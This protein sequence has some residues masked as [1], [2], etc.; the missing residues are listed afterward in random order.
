MTVLHAAARRGDLTEI[1]QW[2]AS[3]DDPNTRQYGDGATP[4]ICAAGS[5]AAGVQIVQ[6]LVKA[7]ADAFLTDTT[8]GQTA[9][10]AAAAIGAVD[11]VAYLLG[12]G[13]DADHRD[14]HGY[15]PIIL[16]GYARSPQK[17]EVI[18]LLLDHGANA[19]RPTIYK[20]TVVGACAHDFDMLRLFDR[21]K[22]INILR[23][24]PLMAATAWDT[25]SVM[26]ST[27]RT[28]P[29]FNQQDT[30]QRTVWHIAIETGDIAKVRWLYA[31][32]AMSMGEDSGLYPN[33]FYALHHD[34]HHM[35]RWLIDI[36]ADASARSTLYTPFDYAAMQGATTCLPLLIDHVQPQHPVLADALPSATDTQTI[37]ILLKAGAQVNHVCS[38]GT[39]ALNAA[40]IDGDTERVRVLLAHGA[41]PNYPRIP[42]TPLI[43][44]VGADHI[45]V[46]QVLLEAG[47]DPNL[48]TNPDMWFAL[49][50]VRSVRVMRL[51]LDAGADPTL[52]DAGGVTAYQELRDPRLIALLDG[53]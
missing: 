25:F 51:L 2:L 15:A 43:C 42:E 17:R 31:Q 47:A 22:V 19:Y 28:D 36:G 6:A 5:Q 52:S 32:P 48:Q 13:M 14:C 35:L 21:E 38:D 37:Q 18:Q 11:T 7:G 53:G 49:Q 30:S 46:V 8:N 23:W 29:R 44:A 3:G 40:A 12:L 27:A 50:Y 4:L 10:H 41:D 33:I 26:Q 45:E 1:N 24:T 39:T 16:A 9:L 20:E 34:H